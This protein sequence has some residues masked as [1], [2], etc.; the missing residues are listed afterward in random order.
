MPKKGGANLNKN[1][2]LSNA[3]N[4]AKKINNNISLSNN[5]NNNQL[6]EGK[7]DYTKIII[8]V[9]AVII[10]AVLAFVAYKYITSKKVVGIKTNQLVPYI[11]DGKTMAR[12]SFGNIPVGTERNSYNYNLWVY[13]NDYDYR[14]GEDK[15]LLFKGLSGKSVHD[16]DTNE[17]PG[18]Y[19]LKNTN[20]LRVLINLET[21]Y[22]DNEDKANCN[23]ETEEVEE[24][25]EIVSAPT[26]PLANNALVGEAAEAAE[27][28]EGEVE[29]LETFVGHHPD[30]GLKNGCDHCDIEHFPLQKWVSVNIAVTENVLDISLDGKLV[31][32]CIL[33]G[34]PKVNDNDLLVCPEGGFNGFISN[35]KVS[36]KALSVKDIKSHYD[37][38]PT[39]KP[40]ILK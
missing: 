8:I 22:K 25:T 28:A 40:G 23:S 13:V 24:I 3:N 4:V 1:I 21:S 11:H 33:T 36:S 37:K 20:T 30:D 15:C 39:L 5:N 34:S 38:G 2:S 9:L 26:D 10:A 6:V 29:L 12:F 27:A 18:V 32:S 7:K 14:S 35:L 19:L 17:N 31:K 16:L